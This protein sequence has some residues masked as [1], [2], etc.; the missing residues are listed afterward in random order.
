MPSATPTRAKVWLWM[1]IAVAVLAIG[2]SAVG[3]LAEEQVY[4][5]ETPNWA[6]QAVG[7]DIANLVAFPLMMILA[8]AALRGS[9]RA[10]IAWLGVV[11]YSAYSYAIYAFDIHFG[12]LFLVWVA[13]L[14][15]SAYALIGAL[16]TLDPARVKSAYAERVPTRSASAIL[17]T[18]AGAFSLLWLAEI[19]PAMFSGTPPETLAEVGLPTNPVQVLDLAL[20]LPAAALAGVL[21]AR[22]RPFGYVLAPSMLVA[23]VLLSIGIVSLTL[24]VGSR[25]LGAAPGVAVAI[26]LLTVV[27]LVAAVALLRRIGNDELRIAVREGADGTRDQAATERTG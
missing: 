12:P 6:A 15:L 4:G 26:A 18:I 3:L 24:V 13:I 1:S 17:L 22:H 20:F 9:L 25:G 23:M 11:I 16:T 10:Y 7:Q 19:I 21:L 8:I 2:A 5:D 27:E 14:G